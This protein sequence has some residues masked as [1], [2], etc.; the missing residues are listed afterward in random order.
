MKEQRH[1]EEENKKIKV[2]VILFEENK[3]KQVM[4]G[5]KWRGKRE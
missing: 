5:C 4:G 3:E 2:L 1:E